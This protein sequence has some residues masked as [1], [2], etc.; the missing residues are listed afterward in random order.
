[1]L[2]WSLIFPNTGNLSVNV[3]FNNVFISFESLLWFV[4]PS[5]FWTQWCVPWCVVSMCCISGRHWE[6]RAGMQNLEPGHLDGHHLDRAV[7][8]DEVQLKFS[9]LHRLANC[10]FAKSVHMIVHLGISACSH[11]RPSGRLSKT[12]E[13]FMLYWFMDVY[14]S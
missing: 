8:E 5:V 9:T 3:G 14:G 4:T 13:K 12:C 2:K 10:F 6:P 1:M 11:L 7:T